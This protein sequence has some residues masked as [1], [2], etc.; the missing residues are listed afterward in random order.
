MSEYTIRSIYILL[1]DVTHPPT[2]AEEAV[3]SVARKGKACVL[4]SLGRKKKCFQIGVEIWSHKVRH[5]EPSILIWDVVDS[6]ITTPGREPV[7]QVSAWPK[8]FRLDSPRVE[9]DPRIWV[10]VVYLANGLRCTG[11]ETG[12]FDR[13][14]KKSKR[15]FRRVD[16]TGAGTWGFIQ[17]KAPVRPCTTY[18][19]VILPRG[20]EAGGTYPSAAIHHG[21]FWGAQTLRLLTCP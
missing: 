14:H 1:K 6:H 12:R 3:A 13:G 9:W 19:R 18:F 16:V 20:K 15:G 10:Q 7:D 5:S 8:S 17:L 11:E 4:D 21:C 2:E